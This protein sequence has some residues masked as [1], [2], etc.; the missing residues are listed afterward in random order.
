LRRLQRNHPDEYLVL[1]NLAH[2]YEHQGLVGD[3]LATFDHLLEIYPDDPDTF[4]G[5]RRLLRSHPDI[6]E[7]LYGR[8]T[9]IQQPPL[10]NGHLALHSGLTIA[11]AT[12]Q[13]VLLCQVEGALAPNLARAPAWYWWQL[14]ET[15]SY[16]I[17][18]F[19]LEFVYQPYRS[20]ETLLPLDI[21]HPQTVTWLERLDHADT[22]TLQVHDHAQNYC[23][24]RRL[25]HSAEQRAR[26]RSLRDRAFNALEALL[27]ER[28]DF[29][30]AIQE[31]E[32]SDQTTRTV[33][34]ENRAPAQH[35]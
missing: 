20:H 18:R 16:P 27:P 21:V 12:Q 2:A 8:A 24:T 1:Q 7:E 17:L 28:R 29:R 34:K 25:S 22:I 9:P 5:V 26:L 11:L 13:A 15:A 14:L 31:I 35:L 10:L 23:F 19:Y 6:I 32:A 3:A 30:A 33:E 4:A